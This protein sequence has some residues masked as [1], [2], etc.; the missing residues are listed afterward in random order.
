MLPG[1]WIDIAQAFPDLPSLNV[2]NAPCTSCRSEARERFVSLN[3]ENCRPM[4][5]KRTAKHKGYASDRECWYTEAVR[6]VEN[7]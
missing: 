7:V 5:Y 3:S 6:E 2:Y 4:R 1:R